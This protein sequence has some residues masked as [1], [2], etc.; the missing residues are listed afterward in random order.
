MSTEAMAS[1][2]IA[3]PVPVEI[4]NWAE[5]IKPPFVKNTT[6]RTYVIDPAAPLNNRNVQITD[7]E[8]NR[9]RMAILVIDAG[10]S[11]TT[12]PPVNSPDVTSTTLAPQGA[13]LPPNAAAGNLTASPYEFFG[14]NAFW[15]NPVST[16]TRVTIIKEYS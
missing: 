12:E 6:V 3:S 15:L 13:Y 1:D 8:P 2:R 10:V 9:L 7:Y 14:P 16:V 4:K 11:I 5:P